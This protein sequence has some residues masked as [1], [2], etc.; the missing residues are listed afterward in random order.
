MILPF[1]SL[2]KQDAE[3]VLLSGIVGPDSIHSAVIGCVDATY[4]L[5]NKIITN[6]IEKDILVLVLKLMKTYSEWI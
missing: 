2:V 4:A 5:D 6:R 1:L 3:F